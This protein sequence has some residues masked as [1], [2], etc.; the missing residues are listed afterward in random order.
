MANLMIGIVDN[1]WAVQIENVPDLA[2]TFKGADLATQAQWVREFAEQMSEGT[3]EFAVTALEGV[4]IDDAAL[5]IQMFF[6]GTTGL[7]LEGEVVIVAAD[8]EALIDI[9]VEAGEAL[10]AML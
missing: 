3:A 5:A 7:V 9:L 4:E 2:W 10:L 8:N 1:A 6:D